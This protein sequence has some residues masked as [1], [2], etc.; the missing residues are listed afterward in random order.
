VIEIGQR[1]DVQSSS[2]STQFLTPSYFSLCLSPK[3][4]FCM[5]MNVE[6]PDMDLGHDL[7]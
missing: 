1:Q 5:Y 7:R 2:S 3:A 6:K 4:H